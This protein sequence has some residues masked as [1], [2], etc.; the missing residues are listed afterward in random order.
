MQ[1]SSRDFLSLSLKPV[2]IA[3]AVAV[4]VGLAV[5]GVVAWKLTSNSHAA[6]EVR[7][8]RADAR[9]WA[10]IAQQ[11]RQA[12]VDQAVALDQAIRRLND[13]SQG[14][15]DDKKAI[16]ALGQT[17]RADLAHLAATRPDLRDIDLG[18]DFLRHWNAANTEP[19]AGPATPGPAAKPE[20]AVPAASDSQQ[21]QPAGAAGPARHRGPDVSRLPQ[22]QRPLDSS[23]N[24]MARNRVALVLRDGGEGPSVRRALHG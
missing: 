13:I 15:E 10:D 12:S 16:Q 3:L 22:R 4:L 21:R 18:D 2:L 24:A 20:A 1:L 23:C 5:G 19:A 8:L 6:Q 7:T 11:Q 14:R 9:E 17:L